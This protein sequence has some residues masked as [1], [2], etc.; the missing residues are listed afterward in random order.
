MTT[1]G[2]DIHEIIGDMELFRFFD[3]TNVLITGCSGLIGSML[4]KAF[5][6][7]NREYGFRIGVI[8]QARDEGR[9]RAI[10]GDTA[11]RM[12]LIIS[13]D[14]S[15]DASCDFIFHTASPTASRFFTDHPVETIDT[16]VFG[17]K[18]MLELAKKNK[19]VFVYLSSMEEYGV[20][21]TPGEVM[22][23]DRTGIIDHLTPRSCYPQGKRMCECMC[24][25]YAA[26]Y[27]V[28]AK[29]ARLA[30]TFGAGIPLSDNRVSMQFAKSV[31]NGTD[32]VL[33]TEGRSISNFCYLTDAV[34]GILTIARNGKAGEAYNICNDGETRSIYEI[35]RLVAEEAAGGKIR[36]V[37]DIPSGVNFGYAPDTTI[38]L[39]S[40]KL[41][42]LGWEPRVSMAE[43]YKR[44]VRYIEEN[45][46][47][48]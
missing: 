22:T 30:Q 46:Q 40:E 16:I 6:A 35:A 12:T 47:T 25:A 10:L 27:A 31:V 34:S 41:K 3:N 14:F 44:L 28:P 29:I 42:R 1:V 37:K 39:C 32:I 11:D 21:Y 2:T 48:P 5:D 17:T 8:G 38:R 20:P 26:E 9:A 13:G 45:K 7:A 4:A 23:E 43:G 15:F 33:H 18:A 36:V 19:A 24:A